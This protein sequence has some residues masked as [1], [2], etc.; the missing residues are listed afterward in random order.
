VITN[1]YTLKALTQI[2]RSQCE[3]GVV[4]EVFSHVKD[5]L[6]LAY[7]TAAGEDRMLRISVDPT[8]RFVFGTAG[9]HRARRNVATLFEEVAGR[10]IEAVRLADRDRVLY[11]DLSRGHQVQVHLYGPRANVLLVNLETDAPGIV[12]RAFQNEKT[13]QDRPAPVA[14]PAP[15]IDTFEAFE[16]RWD[17]RRTSIAQAVARAIPLFNPLLAAEVMH[18]ARVTEVQ[19]A[20]CDTD[21]RRRLFEAAQAL[22]LQLEQ[23][24]P[25]IYWRGP[26]AEVFSLIPL[27]HLEKPNAVLKVEAFDN[28]D[29]AV[30]VFVRKQWG[31]RHFLEQYQPLEKALRQAHERNARRADDM[32]EALSQESRADQYEHW[33]HVLMASG[34]SG[35]AG[36]DSVTVPDPFHEA[37]PLTIPLDPRQ[38]VVQNAEQYYARARQVRQARIHAE[39]RLGEAIALSTQ[40]HALWEHMQRITTLAEL[41]AFKKAEQEAIQRFIRPQAVGEADV[42]FRRFVVDGGYEV[43]VGR[44]ARENDMLTLQHARKYDLWF[45][46]RGVPGSHVVLRRPERQTEP[47]KPALEA[48]ASIAAHYSQAK[49]SKLVPVQFTER[50]YVVKPK[51]AAPGAVRLLREH[52]LLVEPR[53]PE[54]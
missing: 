54:R 14:R 53:V 8:F 51:G 46:A 27:S 35:E 38:T 21:T 15:H 42:P 41:D 19:S 30:R 16:A 22:A 29:H 12:V 49:H 33:G 6:T 9:Y 36:A 34:L 40:N 2:W 7:V 31:Q 24:V 52:V 20:G 47:G 17:P 32:L 28:P 25:C 5:E 43:W 48:A 23:P 10:T 18:R 26:L 37:R 45:H 1:Y 11:L 13:W 44:N 50:K 39:A 4:R 3:G